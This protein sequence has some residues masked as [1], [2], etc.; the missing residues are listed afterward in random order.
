MTTDTLSLGV[1]PA[2][3]K[4]AHAW[5]GSAV[6]VV[7]VILVLVALWYVAAVVVREKGRPVVDDIIYLKDNDTPE[8]W[9]LSELLANGCKGPRW[10]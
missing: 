4:A 1:R 8:E 9:R 10:G 7:A 6:P 3:R 5:Q 2:P